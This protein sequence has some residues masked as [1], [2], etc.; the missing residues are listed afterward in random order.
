M[1]GCSCHDERLVCS[2][3]VVCKG[4]WSIRLERHLIYTPLPLT[5]G[6]KLERITPC[7]LPRLLTFVSCDDL[8]ASK[9]FSQVYLQA[10]NDPYPQYTM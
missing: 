8:L 9:Q 7:S 2:L 3:A 6:Y 10:P 5:E 4:C 1:G